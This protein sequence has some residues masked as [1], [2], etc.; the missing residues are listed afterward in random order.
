[1]A[2]LTRLFLKTSLADIDRVAVWPVAVLVPLTMSV[3]PPVEGDARSISN[4][5]I[6]IVLFSRF[7]AVGIF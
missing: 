2:A 3:E 1:M 5:G 4:L 7:R 6:G